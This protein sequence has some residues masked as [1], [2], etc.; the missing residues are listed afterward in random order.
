MNRDV[1]PWG[2]V[3]RNLELIYIVHRFSPR[4]SPLHLKRSTRS[5]CSARPK[6]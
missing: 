3:E 2:A 5:T 6:L 4:N 1:D